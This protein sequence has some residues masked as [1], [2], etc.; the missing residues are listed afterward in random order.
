MIQDVS[1]HETIYLI[2][3]G[4]YNQFT[5][6][7]VTYLATCRSNPWK[8]AYI[9][10]FLSHDGIGEDIGGWWQRA[11]HRRIATACRTQEDD[12][13]V[14]EAGDTGR[15]WDRRAE[16]RRMPQIKSAHMCGSAM[17]TGYDPEEKTRLLRSFQFQRFQ[18]IKTTWVLDFRAQ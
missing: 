14:Q 11:G 2:H 12:D 13:G 4:L 1:S 10:E 3:M 6:A 8:Q 7:V 16:P 9:H 5:I 15:E 17:S 18:A